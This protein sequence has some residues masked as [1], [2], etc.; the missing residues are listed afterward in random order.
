MTEPPI[1]IE[2]TELFEPAVDQALVRQRQGRER[3]IADAP[4]A[5]PLRR[6]L[7]NSMFYLPIA[8]LIGALVTWFLLDKHINDRPMVSGE[9]NLIN[10][11]PFAM[12]SGFVSLTIGGAEVLLDPSTVHLAPGAHGEPAFASAEQLKVGDRIE[13]SG[14]ADDAHRVIAAAIR[15]TSDPTNRAHTESSA[16]AL[17]LL[18]PLTASLIAFCLL[19]AE[20]VSTRNWGRTIV[21]TLLGALLAAVFALLALVPVGLILMISQRVISAQMEGVNLAV[22]TSHDMTALAFFVET[23]CRSAA[24]ACVGAG[25]GLG[26]NLVRST[27]AQLRN[28]VIGGAL[29][30]ALGGLFFDPIDRL[31]GSVFTSGSTSRL[32]GLIAVGLAI[33]V[34]V[35]LVERLA[36]EAWLRVRTGPLAGKSFILYKTP[37]TIGN[38]PSSDVYLYKD[39]EIDPS[40]AMIHRVGAAYEIEDLATRMGTRVA[41]AAIRRRRLASGDQIVI[42]STILDFEERQRR[43][44]AG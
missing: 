36:R 11:E 32:V 26:M 14:I 5:S 12:P 13:A 38:A 9:I 10:T 8:A 34:F 18:F 41:G 42:G 37:T 29:G 24:W 43:T 3:I 27:R 25:I 28:S 20:G 4:V 1:R 35:A 7:N 23:A 2:R 19:F 22:Y 33:G 6:L 30:G 16:A 21:R 31:F 17:G 15:P 40:H 44:P 39:A